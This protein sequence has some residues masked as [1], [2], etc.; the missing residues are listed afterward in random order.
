MKVIKLSRGKVTLVDDEDYE[1]LNQ[2]SWSVKGN[3]DTKWDANRSLYARRA[4]VIDGKHISY[5]M[6]REI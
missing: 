2:Y 1:N 4:E 3:K 6:H 5:S